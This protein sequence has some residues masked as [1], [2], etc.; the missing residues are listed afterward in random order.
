LRRDGLLSYSQKPSLGKSDGKYRSISVAVSYLVEGRTA[1]LRKQRFLVKH[2]VNLIFEA[3]RYDEPNGDIGIHCDLT[4]QCE[5]ITLRIEVFAL[6]K[7]VDDD[8]SRTSRD[9]EESD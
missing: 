9:W 4:N 2:L 8:Y 3:T 1:S 5:D 7:S 6:V